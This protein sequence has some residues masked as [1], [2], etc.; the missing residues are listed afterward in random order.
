M[1]RYPGEPVRTRT[2]APS[3]R[4]ENGQPVDY[5]VG[6]NHQATGRSPVGNF[7]HQSTF[8][9]PPDS[10]A[11][12]TASVLLETGQCAHF[13]DGMRTEGELIGSPSAFGRRSLHSRHQED[14]TGIK[15]QQTGIALGR[16][17]IGC[18]GIQGIQDRPQ[19]V[20]KFL[21]RPGI[22]QNGSMRSRS[23]AERAAN[24]PE[25]DRY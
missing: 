7:V 10:A 12:G 9:T 25:P 4:H 15:D 24:G 2:H 19:K 13:I 14:G 20:R 23:D 5:R 22:G 18:R 21:R 8:E 6:A 17:R 1:V 16:R 11:P 3:G